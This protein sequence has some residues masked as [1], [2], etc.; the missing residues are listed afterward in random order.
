MTGRAV[1][2]SSFYLY[3]RVHVER[4]YGV[5]T[6]FRLGTSKQSKLRKPNEIDMGTARS[7]FSLIIRAC[8]GSNSK[9]DI[10]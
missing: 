5:K 8:G 2:G 10:L 7:H 4:E 6:E 1:R 9:L 3:S